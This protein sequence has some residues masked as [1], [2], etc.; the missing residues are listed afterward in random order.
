MNN[1]L[2]LLVDGH[3][4][5]F[6]AYY[7]L[8]EL[9]SPE[10][11]PT[12]AV[13]GFANMLLK[14]VEEL[15]PDSVGVIFDAPGPT[16]RHEAYEAYKE[17]RQPTPEDFKAQM[18]HI[19]SFARLLGYQVVEKAGV[20]ADDVIAGTARA[21]AQQGKKVVVLTADKDMLQVL[22]KNVTVLRPLKGVSSF[23]EWSEE[24]FWEEY[25]FGP[26]SMPDYLALVGDKV[27]NIP[28][29]KGIGDKS[30]RNLLAK[31]GTLEEIYEKIDEQPGALKKKLE[32]GK[33]QAFSG[34]ELTRLRLTETLDMEKLLPAVRDETGLLSLL[35]RLALRKLA[36]KLAPDHSS[37]VAIEQV[38]EEPEISEISLERI[39][40]ADRLFM[41]WEGTGDYPYDYSLRSICLQDDS[42]GAWSA[43][44]PDRRSIEKIADWWR[45]GSIVTTG[46]KELCCALRDMAPEPQ[47]VW[48]IRIAHY[49]LH[50]DLPSHDPQPQGEDSPVTYCGAIRR[51]METLSGEI[52]ERGLEEIMRTVD[53]PLS[54][55][56]ARMELYGVGQ[57]TEKLRE[58]GNDLE[59]RTW[60]ILNS[61]D[62]RAGV[63]IN[64]NSPKQV[65]WLLFEHL[66]YPPVKKTK[67]GLSTDVSVLETLAS[68]PGNPSRVPS[69]MLEYREITKMFSGFVQPLLKC[70]TRSGGVVHTTLEQ[71]V[72]GTGR[73]SSRDPNLQNLPAY[74]R[75]AQRLRETLTPHAPGRV[76]VA[77]D[78][79]QVELRVLA[80][81]S[82]EAMLQ[83]AF[84]DGRDIHT[85]TA[86]RIFDAP[87][88]EISSEQRRYA[89]MVNF[90]LLYG[91][92][93]YGLARRLGIGR[94]E[95]SEII[96]RYF[97]AF[98]R[99]RDYLK[100]SAGESVARGYT[101]TL[102]GRVRPLSEVSTIEGR[103]GGAINRVAVNTPIQGTAADIARLAMIRFDSAVQKKNL[104]APLVLQVHDSLVCETPSQDREEITLLLADEMEKA[105]D[106]AVPLAVS[107]KSGDTFADI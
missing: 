12:N 39:L 71:T 95:A 72:T 35:D 80:H 10:G 57:N 74:G 14:V 13:L 26:G 33:E 6:R 22:E 85:E 82:G 102:L 60:E 37:V 73:L 79:S 40:E 17:N 41:A 25:G 50:P 56:L 84:A 15:Q 42:G 66:G 64:L 55:V 75:W 21:A 76:F 16:F 103:G 34:R 62:E 67:T 27:D 9:T 11:L 51:S 86:R 20:E 87:G 99:V 81:L 53:L 101:K 88:E 65:A 44:D 104:D 97:G 107:I 77:G 58:L 106:L 92:T 52:R 63:H 45:K 59:E 24:S 36:E 54:R 19:R 18:P 7:A 28:G 8:P 94:Q 5:A 30:A 70:G 90:G 61:I 1:D 48:D 38:R 98:P 47:N 29:V 49:L 69:L 105:F 43:E 46:Y 68:L 31:C 93:D 96:E 78:Y 89:K 100:Q 23:R 32:A 3:G 4:L 83:Q 91:M 2:L